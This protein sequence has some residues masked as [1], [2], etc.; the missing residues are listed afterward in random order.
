MIETT[1]HIYWQSI[2]CHLHPLEN[3]YLCVF[4]TDVGSVKAN[5]DCDMLIDLVRL[6]KTVVRDHAL[7]SP[8]DAFDIICEALSMQGDSS[9]DEVIAEIEKLIPEI[10]RQW[11]QNQKHPYGWQSVTNATEYLDELRGGDAT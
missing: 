8:G 2:Q 3:A 10:N 5:I 11:M 6:H 9:Q 7:Q 1:P 4:R